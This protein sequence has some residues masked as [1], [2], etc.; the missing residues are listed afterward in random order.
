MGVRG[1]GV[2]VEALGEAVAASATT[3]EAKSEGYRVGLYT[4]MDVLD[5]TR[6]LYRAKRDHAEARYAFVFNLLLLKQ[7]AGALSEDD[8]P[9][10]NNWLQ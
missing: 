5:A 10:V 2:R 4:A 6:D 3:L 9:L 8:L 7:A 1:A